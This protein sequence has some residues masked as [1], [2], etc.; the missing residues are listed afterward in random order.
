MDLQA[1][2]DLVRE[3]GEEIVTADELK[4]LLETKLRP[5]AYDG[6][7]PSGKMHIAQGILRAINV[8]KMTSAGMKFKMLVANWHAWANNKLGGN[9]ENIKT[10]GEYFI[11]VWKS[12]GMDLKNVEFVWASDLLDS[13]DYWKTVL[14]VS[15]LNTIKR[16]LRTS[17]IM[18][19]KE[20]D[21]LHASQLIYPCM[22]VADIFRLEADIAQLGMDQRK[23]NMLARE[24]GEKAGYWKPVVVSHHMLLGLQGPPK[25][26]T[27]AEERAMEMKMSKSK[28]DSAIFMTDSAPEVE[29]KLSKA[30]CP[31]KTIEGNPILEYAKYIVFEKFKSVEIKRHSKF[32][33]DVE[34]QSY[35]ELE[36]AFASGKL[37]PMDLKKA[38]AGKLNELLAPVR[39]HFENDAKAKKL[40]EQVNGFEVTR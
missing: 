7:E 9:L 28:P 3:V 4:Q 36:F 11:E 19:R 17:E 5:I 10:T 32:G 39:A 23:V 31:E 8:N 18:G 25:N 22:Q 33:G 21:V 13:R 15:R 30:Y 27:N 12:T 38:V 24:V 35:S 1:R 20:S 40:V 16:V 34:F 29:S 37:H 6:F 26:A 14:E 2:L